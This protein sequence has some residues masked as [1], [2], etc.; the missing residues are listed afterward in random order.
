MLGI[1]AML[2]NKASLSTTWNA[3]LQGD[4]RDSLGIC[5]QIGRKVWQLTPN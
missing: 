5:I 2:P 4:S 1:A 3:I